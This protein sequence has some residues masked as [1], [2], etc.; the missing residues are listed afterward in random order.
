MRP[1]T[2][3]A[4]NLTDFHKPKKK[5]QGGTETQVEVVTIGAKNLEHAKRIAQAGN[6]DPW[7][8]VPFHNTKNIIYAVMVKGGSHGIH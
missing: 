3:L 7:Y 6:N 8:V 1:K 5:W 4:I 2:Y